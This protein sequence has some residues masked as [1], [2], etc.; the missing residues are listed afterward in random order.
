MMGDGSGLAWLLVSFTLRLLN[1][2]A[3]TDDWAAVS[4][5]LAKSVAPRLKALR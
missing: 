2:W 4:L 1:D 5:V 3:N